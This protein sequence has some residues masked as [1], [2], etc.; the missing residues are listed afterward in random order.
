M[1]T[2]QGPVDKSG[3]S[4]TP[5]SDVALTVKHF[6]G[7]GPQELGLDPHYSFGKTQVYPGGNFGGHLK[8]FEA[9]IAASVSSIMPYYGVP[10]NVTYKGVSYE[11]TGKAFSK[12]IVT[13]LLR[14]EL[15]FR[16]YVNSDTGIINDRAWGEK[17]TVPE[18]VAAAV[19]G[20]SDTLSG[21]HD[22]ATITSLTSSGHPGAHR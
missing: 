16:G 2:L 13:D 6:P 4:L 7:G 12:Q 3:V 8:P 10:V 20:G 11:Q 18:R 9:A 19:K 15:G 5:K 21:F 1:K 14:G 17:K 22:V